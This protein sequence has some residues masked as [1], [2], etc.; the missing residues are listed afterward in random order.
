MLVT[1]LLYDTDISRTNRIALAQADL[2]VARG[3]RVRIVT[4]GLPLTW[5]TSRA[6]WM[7]VD[8]FREY[9]PGADEIV[10]GAESKILD[11]VTIVDDDVYR[12]RLPRENEPLRVLLAGAWQN[13]EK[14]IDDGYGAV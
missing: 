6:E 13:Q 4:K 10:V 3:H 12:E 11:E 1:Y 7:F 8:D 2:L 9:A 5:R 14:G